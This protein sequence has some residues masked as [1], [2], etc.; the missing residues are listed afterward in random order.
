MMDERRCT[1]GFS[2]IRVSGHRRGGDWCRHD[3]ESSATLSD[4]RFHGV[5]PRQ[6]LKRGPSRNHRRRQQICKAPLTASGLAVKS[7]ACSVS[8][9]VSNRNGDPWCTPPRR[10]VLQ[11]PPVKG[12]S[13]AIDFLLPRVLGRGPLP[14]ANGP[15]R[16][17]HNATSSTA[18]PP[19][20]PDPCGENQ[21]GPR[22][23]PLRSARCGH[24]PRAHRRRLSPARRACR[25]TSA[26]SS[27]WYSFA[28]PE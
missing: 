3:R 10:N 20:P 11:R 9:P 22:R 6:A 2:S 8:N 1:I 28:M 21:A 25:R 15:N 18:T 26:G 4:L 27:G 14:L 16:P 12:P 19:N 13:T 7:P 17:P 5:A 23:Q 24:H